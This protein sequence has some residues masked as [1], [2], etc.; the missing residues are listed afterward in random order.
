MP[1]DL[2]VTLTK[3]KLFFLQVQQLLLSIIV[4][5]GLLC[6]KLKNFGQ[7]YSV[8]VAKDYFKDFSYLSNK[9]EL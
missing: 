2:K 8:G 5:N 4:A 9:I 6:K 1:T 7:L 3:G